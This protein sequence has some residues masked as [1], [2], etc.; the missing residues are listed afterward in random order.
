MTQ[1]S[2]HI[3]LWACPRSRSKALTRAFEQLDGCDIYD[4]PLA[5]AYLLIEGQKQ[6]PPISKAEIPKCLER[7]HKK[8]IEKMTGAIPNGSTFLFYKNLSQYVLPKFG[9]EWI[10]KLTN[11]FLIRHLKETIFSYW[12]T[13][14]KINNRG[15]GLDTTL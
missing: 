4:E 5:G 9:I 14:K 15:S 8:V 1:Y 7:D 13:S 6:N 10:K 2:Q 3:A 11:V 12:K